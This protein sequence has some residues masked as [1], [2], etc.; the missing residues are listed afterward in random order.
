MLPAREVPCSSSC[1]ILFGFGCSIFSSLLLSLFHQK[2][3]SQN[4]I[5]RHMGDLGNLVIPAIDGS[6]GSVFTITDAEVLGGVAAILNRTIVLHQ[7]EV[8]ADF[9]FWKGH[10]NFLKE[11]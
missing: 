9:V 5:V 7:W 11:L 10:V 3:G 4:S 1:A 6:G 8:C 2:H